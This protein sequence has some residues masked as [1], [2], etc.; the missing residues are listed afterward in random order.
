MATLE[1]QKLRVLDIIL[2]PYLTNP[3][4]NKM[5]IDSAIA[6]SQVQDFVL[7]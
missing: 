6:K 4:I 7:S 3:N 5:F 1:D 2:N